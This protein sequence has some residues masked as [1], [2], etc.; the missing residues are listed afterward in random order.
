MAQAVPEMLAVP[1]GP[2]DLAGD[3]IDRTA[4]RQVATST[5]GLVERLHRGRLGACDELVHLGV[6]RRRL[7]HEQRSGHVA[8][9][10]TDLRT[11][12]EQQDGAVRHRPVSGCAVGQR[13]L[14]PRQ[15]R[16]VERERLRT[17]RPH[18]PLEPQ[19]KVGLADTRTDLG[20]QRG[21]RAVGH[22]AGRGDP[23]DLGGLLGR[24]ILLDPA[25][26]RHELDVWRGGSKTLPDGVRDERRLDTDPLRTDR[27]DELGPAGL[28]IAVDDLDP[29]LRRLAAR[30]DLVARIGEQ[31]EI[32]ARHQELPGVA[33]DL[34]LAVG[35]G[36]PRE[37]AHV[38][39]ADAE[40]GID[41]CAG[42]SIADP[43][44]TNGARRPVSLLPA[45]EVGRGR[46]PGEVGRARPRGTGE[47]HGM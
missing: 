22:R 9:I 4:R 25:F 39:A 29:G 43:F 34:L 18:R 1:G 35:E 15:A 10:A 8:S 37:V 24:P 30:L 14:R 19:R 42:E 12:V 26:D 6:P 44:A 31:D 20:E 16:D 36:E 28:E 27:A 45:H 11:E 47:R 7:A 21:E 23:L 5:K 13:R 40:V 32:V 46:W 3:G 41:A 38:L 33:G 17:A 2:D